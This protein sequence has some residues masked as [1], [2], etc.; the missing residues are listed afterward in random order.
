MYICGL[1]LV[2]KHMKKILIFFAAATLAAAC[3]SPEKMAKMA[4]NVQVTCEPSVL[5]V[6]NGTIDPVVTVTYPRII[7]IPR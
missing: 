4:N 6:V 1:A 5:E 7:S 2:L 3:A